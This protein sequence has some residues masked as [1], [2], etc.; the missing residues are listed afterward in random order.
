MDTATF[1][2]TS[3]LTSAGGSD[4][5][6]LALSATNGLVEWAIRAGGA[7]QDRGT[8]LASDGNGK[9][10]LVAQLPGAADFQGW[11]LPELDPTP[12]GMNLLVAQ[13]DSKGVLLRRAAAR[14]AYADSIVV[15]PAGRIHLAGDFTGLM[16]YGP[17]LHT[18][19]TGTNASSDV[20]LAQLTEG[21]SALDWVD[22]KQIGGIG[23]ET[24]GTVSVDPA[25]SVV[26]S[27]TYAQ[28]LHLGYVQVSTPNPQEIFLARLDAEGIY[29]HNLWE[30]GEPLR[31]PDEALASVP[32]NR[33]KGLL[34]I[35]IL[36]MPADLSDSDAGNSFIW[37]EEEKR[38]YA[39][40]PVTARI[41]WRLD[42]NTTNLA[43]VATMVGRCIWPDHPQTNVAGAPVEVQGPGVGRSYFCAGI[44]FNTNDA[45]VARTTRGAEQFQVFQTTNNASGYNVIHYLTKLG[46]GRSVFDVVY[47]R[48]YAHWTAVETGRPNVGKALERGRHQD[49][50]RKNG[51]VFLKIPSMM[52]QL[53]I[54]STRTGPDHS[55]QSESA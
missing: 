36:S 20:F 5:F 1:P 27:G 30:I 53:T 47:T 43:S 18:V 26:V 39:I 2:G 50:T 51:Y 12:S 44:V 3:S 46:S 52:A 10:Y 11:P 8:A 6:V 9:I 48:P 34:S 17:T 23:I 55:R 42:E 38:L 29:E 24:R 15:T 33:A 4:V 37:N 49:S 16:Q 40:R 28:S 7:G 21:V 22:F 41:K 45:S 25:G 13:L 31:P 19:G 32:L 35:E 14:A 54:A